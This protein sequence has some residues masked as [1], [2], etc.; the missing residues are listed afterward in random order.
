MSTEFLQ[1][2]YKKYLKIAAPALSVCAISAAV[3]ASAATF[4]A[5]FGQGAALGQIHV[6]DIARSLNAVDDVLNRP[7]FRLFPSAVQKEHHPAVV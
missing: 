5:A 4:P 6:A 2:F 1:I 3:F 7:F